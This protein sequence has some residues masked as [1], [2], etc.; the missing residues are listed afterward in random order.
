MIFNSIYQ[1]Y[2]QCP[3]LAKQTITLLFCSG[4]GALILL[5]LGA[6]HQL[7]YTTA[8]LSQCSAWLGVLI[9]T[10][11]LYFTLFPALRSWVIRRNPVMSLSLP[12]YVC[13][14]LGYGYSLYTVCFVPEAENTFFELILVI[15]FIWHTVQLLHSLCQQMIQRAILNHKSHTQF[16][17]QSLEKNGHIEPKALRDIRCGQKLIIAPGDYFPLDGI[18]LEGA[19]QVDLSL[20]T[21]DTNH[22]K[23]NCRDS[24]HAGMKNLKS[25]VIIMVTSTLEKSTYAKQYCQHSTMPDADPI[26]PSEPLTLWLPV[27]IVTVV[28]VIAC[29]WLPYDAGFSLFCAISSLLLACPLTIAIAYPLTCISGLLLCA[30][31][32]IFIRKSLALLH[33]SQINHVIFENELVT[34]QSMHFFNDQALYPI[35]LSDPTR[36]SSPM[37]TFSP[38]LW[39]SRYAPISSKRDMTYSQDHLIKTLMIGQSFPAAYTLKR[40]CIGLCAKD[41]DPYALISADIVFPQINAQSLSTTQSISQLTRRHL[42]QNVLLALVCQISI[43]PFSA[44]GLLGPNDILIGLLIS[45]LLIVGNIGRMCLKVWDVTYRSRETVFG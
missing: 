28:S 25:T 5:G 30:Q 33:F 18:I 24:I 40:A 35:A 11:L 23:K 45:V 4:L 36:H 27:F 16:Q 43:L 29:W 1:H 20:L 39:D 26:L 13:L 9:T 22:I 37:L 6:I 32:G 10:P 7:S 38:T 12:I 2:R 14:I 42:H 41:A 17:V 44:M 21:G 15:L 31:Q 3:A 34:A 8:H 19:T